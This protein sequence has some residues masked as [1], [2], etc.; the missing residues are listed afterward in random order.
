VEILQFWLKSDKTGRLHE[1][2]HRFVHTRSVK[3]Y[4]IIREFSYF[5]T[6]KILRTYFV[7]CTQAHACVLCAEH[8]QFLTLHCTFGKIRQNKITSAKW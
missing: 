1:E 7:A 3:F 4:T 6:R 8:V 5:G 2:L